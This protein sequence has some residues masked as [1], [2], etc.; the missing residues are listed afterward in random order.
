MNT[1]DPA[2]AWAAH[3]TLNPL[4]DP[5]TDNAPITPEVQTMLNKPAE[6][7]TLSTEDRTFLD[8]V[9]A[10]VDAGTLNLYAPSTLLNTAVYASL[11]PTEQG[12]ADQKAMNIL[13]KLR[14]MVEWERAPM[15]T[16][17]QVASLI[18]AVRLD[19]E[20]FEA[21]KDIFII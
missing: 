18:S 2:S 5:A 21:S 19:K 6:G 3:S 10:L 8:K 7:A 13:T 1:F 17:S 11:N 4:H 12:L 15:D 20:Q 14:T 16:N 9:M